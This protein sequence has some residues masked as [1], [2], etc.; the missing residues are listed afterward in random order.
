MNDGSQARGPHAVAELLRRNTSAVKELL[1]RRGKADRRLKSLREMAAQSGIPCRE[2]DRDELDQLASGPH[3][4]AVAILHESAPPP[5]LDERG[6]LDALRLRGSAAFV[7][8]LDAITDPHN[9]GACLRSADGAGVDAVVI[10]AN[11]S[12]RVNATV[13]KIASGAAETVP[14][15]TATNLARFIDRLKQA[16]I[17]VVG[18]VD[19]SPKVLF[20]QDLTGPVA[21][22][23][24]SEEKGIRRLVREKCDYL[25]AIPMAG[26]L[27][28]LNVSVAAG[29]CL[30]E[31]LRQR[32]GA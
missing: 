4:G 14:V 6:L 3:Q 7:L 29:I 22:V 20:E 21:L 13:R 18:A 9:L 32:R 2:L 23:M 17:W 26:S 24:G 31:V 5:A 25:V 12:V 19:D 1:L 16:G 28:N 27:R 30:F 8:I 15:V 11:K 10:P